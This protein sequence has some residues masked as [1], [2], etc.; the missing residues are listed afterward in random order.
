M[1]LLNVPSGSA[2]DILVSF[3][4][5]DSV[6]YLIKFI[7]SFILIFPLSSNNSSR[8]SFYWQY[9]TANSNKAR[10]CSVSHLLPISNMTISKLGG[11]RVI[12]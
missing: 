2:F 5:G 6:M 1:N 3:P 7:W 4:S 8:E 10:S 12:F 9:F 11:M